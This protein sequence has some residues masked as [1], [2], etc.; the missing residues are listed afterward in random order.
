M[1]AKRTIPFLL[2]LAGLSAVSGFLM[3]NM[4]WIGRIGINLIHK[5]YK[6]LKVWWQGALAVYVALL[7]LFVVQYIIQ[8]RTHFVVGKLL[9]VLCFAAAIGGLYF[10]FSDFSN[11]ITHRM[12]RDVFHV[13]AYLFWVGWMLISIFFLA[14]RRAVITNSDSMEPTA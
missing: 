7:V 13:G 8:K 11:D 6:F 12:L 14:I 9:H 2:L 1:G 4:S 5:E 10:T 3:S